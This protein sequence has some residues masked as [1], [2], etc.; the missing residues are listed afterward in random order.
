ML[1]SFGVLTKA[2]FRGVEPNTLSKGDLGYTYL[3]NAFL[4]VERTD[5]TSVLWETVGVKVPKWPW[6][7]EISC[8]WA[9]SNHHNQG[10][11]FICP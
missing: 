8:S 3:Y 2:T 6:K 7:R 10:D 4:D 9:S 5:G 11:F 1:S